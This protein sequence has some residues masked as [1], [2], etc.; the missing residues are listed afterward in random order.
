MPSTQAQPPEAQIKQQIKD[1]CKEV[2]PEAYVS[3][4]ISQYC[5]HVVDAVLYP[6]GVGRNNEGYVR[7]GGETL[8][9]ALAALKA[10]WIERA[11]L[12]RKETLRKMALQIIGIT[13]DTGACTDAALHQHFD[14]GQVAA[15]SAEAC[16]LANEM[17][18]NGPF[19]VVAVPRSNS[20]A[21]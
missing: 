6:F 1:L 13:A 16:A 14:A 3:L 15:L 12:H 18:G 5:E 21:A 20:E 7:T 10:Q 2:G 11:V 9:T 19:S 4:S 17:A 8:E